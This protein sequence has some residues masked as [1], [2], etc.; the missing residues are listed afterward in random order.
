MQVMDKLRMKNKRD[1]REKSGIVLVCTF[2]LLLAIFFQLNRMDILPKFFDRKNIYHEVIASIQ[3]DEELLAMRERFLLF[4][5]PTS[6]Y[7]TH[8]KSEIEKYLADLKRD[9]DCKYYAESVDF[10]SYKAVI[11]AMDRLTM[12]P[13]AIQRELSTYVEEG[14]SVYLTGSMFPHWLLKQ[15]GGIAAGSKMQT[16]CGVRFYNNALI[17]ADDF[18]CSSEAFKSYFLPCFITD[19][20]KILATTYNKKPL[21]WEREF[22]KG[23][24][25]VFNSFNA[26]RKDWRG[27]FV[28]GLSRLYEDF[29]YPVIGAKLVFIDDF[30]APVPAGKLNNIYNEFKMST[31]DFYRNIWWPDMLNIS[32][33]H[34]IKYT[35]LVVQSFNDRVKAPFIADAGDNAMSNLIVYGRELLKCGGELGIHGY[36]LQPLAPAGYNQDKLGYKAWE[37]MEDMQQSLTALKEYFDSVY[38]YYFMRT[39]VPPANILSPEGKAVVRR[40]FPTVNIFSALYNGPY[41]ERCLY[42]NFGRNSDKTYDIPRISSG[43]NVLDNGYMSNFSLI[44][45]YGISSHFVNP[46]ELYFAEYEGQSWGFYRNSFSKFIN[47]ITSRY[48]WLRPATASE[49]AHFIDIYYGFDYVTNYLENGNLEFLTNGV[50]NAYLIFRTTKEIESVEGCILKELEHGVYLLQTEETN[51]CLIRFKKEQGH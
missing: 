16:D 26:L 44:N 41:E 9:I 22:G 27:V 31:E 18:F 46:N 24:F 14:G 39:Y 28:I 50:P 47:E 42:Q 40:I 37:N 29:S 45:A 36:N 4:Y 12:I 2:V 19:D 6:V 21:L 34:N 43:F 17:G 5:D 7:S 35:G 51:R 38:P 23:K 15:A 30:L 3:L 8:G 20:S 25:V 33:S 49:T 32:I 1:M 10:S 48:P 13:E 11:V